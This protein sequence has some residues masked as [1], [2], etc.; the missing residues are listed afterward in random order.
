VATSDLQ[1]YKNSRDSKIRLVANNPNRTIYIVTD[2]GVND[3]NSTFGVIIT[4]GTHLMIT[5]M[6]TLYTIENFESSYQS[7]LYALLAGII[8]LSNC[9][10]KEARSTATSNKN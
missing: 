9:T 6:G 5:N 10:P 4:N 7:E 2:G 8:T 1:T 3:H